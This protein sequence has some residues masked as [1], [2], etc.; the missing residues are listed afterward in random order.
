MLCGK[1]YGSIVSSL[2]ASGKLRLAPGP[3]ACTAAQSYALPAS[4][5]EA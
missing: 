1:S 2:A 3:R 4:S 5:S